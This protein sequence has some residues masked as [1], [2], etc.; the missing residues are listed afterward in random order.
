[1]YLGVLGR[2]LLPDLAHVPD[3]DAAVRGAGGEDG[4]VEGRPL[5]LEHLV[6]GGLWMCV[7]GWVGIV[8][9]G[10]LHWTGVHGSAHCPS[11]EPITNRAHPLPLSVSLARSLCSPVAVKLV[12]LRLEVPHVPQLEGVV[13][14]ARQ[15]PGVV[16]RLVGGLSYYRG[17][18]MAAAV[19]GR[20]PQ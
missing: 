20:A 2:L 16:E 4:L 12:E 14:G 15:H 5:H 17:Q 9:W 6:A 13:R 1:M 3:V 18:G 11:N 7:L 8:R 19:G 10:G